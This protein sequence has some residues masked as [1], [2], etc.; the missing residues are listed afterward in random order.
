MCSTLSEHPHTDTDVW[1][2]GWEKEGGGRRK[3]T[4]GGRRNGKREEVGKREEDREILCQTGELKT[5]H[6]CS[7]LF[8]LQAVGQR[9]CTHVLQITPAHG[10]IGLTLT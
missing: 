6:H 3:R 5:T 8:M 4:E 1:G 9:T 2:K 7:T 10:G